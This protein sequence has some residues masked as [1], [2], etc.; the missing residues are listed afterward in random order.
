MK[1]AKKEGPAQARA[2]GDKRAAAGPVKGSFV[3][4][5]DSDAEAVPVTGR[6]GRRRLNM[7]GGTV[8]L[9]MV[10]TSACILTQDHAFVC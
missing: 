8:S 9:K 3:E 6:F 4:D 10:I 7:A 1:R 5:S 2:S